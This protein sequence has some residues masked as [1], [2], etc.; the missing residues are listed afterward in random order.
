MTFRTEELLADVIA[1]LI[2]AVTEP[3]D[4][5]VDPAAGS[6][7]VMRA[8]RRL[9]RNFSGCDLVVTN[10]EREAEL[11]RAIADAGTFASAR[12]ID[13]TFGVTFNLY[14]CRLVGVQS[15]GGKSADPALLATWC[16]EL[17][18]SECA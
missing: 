10:P 7:G 3:G 2:G 1:R 15:V 18:R 14:R 5:V 16:R 8:A 4:L 9:E 17:M 13:R 12:Q 11:A 6:F